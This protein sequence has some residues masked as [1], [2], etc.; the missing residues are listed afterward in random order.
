MLACSLE[1]P[2]LACDAIAHRACCAD[3]NLSPSA[4]FACCVISS[5]SFLACESCLASCNA[6]AVLFVLIFEFFLSC[7][8]VAQLSG[9]DDGD[10]A[11]HA[12]A[13]LRSDSR[14]LVDHL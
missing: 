4:R 7:L 14:S 1:V 12:A 10:S 6:R 13:R 2:A 3:V 11:E 8:L 9:D 5:E